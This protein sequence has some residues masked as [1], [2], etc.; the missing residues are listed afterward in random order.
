MLDVEYIQE[1]VR[2]AAFF[3]MEY[4]L[5]GSWA[6]AH[7]FKPVLN[8]SELAAW[9]EIMQIN[10]PEDY[11]T[12]LTKLGNGGAGPAYGI[13]PFH[14]PLYE[15]LKV[16]SIY[17]DENAKLFNKVAQE[18]FELSNTDEE[19][20]Y[21]QYKQNSPQ[22]QKLSFNEWEEQFFDKY[23]DELEQKLMNNG[24]LFIANQG[25]SIDIYMILN[26]TERGKC[27]CTNID[28]DYAY[29]CTNEQ[30]K[31]YN[32]LSE[33][34]P[35]RSVLWSEYKESLTDFKQYLMA[36]VTSVLDKIEDFSIELR[37]QFQ[38][39]REKVLEFEQAMQE[40]DFVG[41]ERLIEKLDPLSFSFKTR[42]YYIESLERLTAEFPNNILLQKFLSNVKYKPNTTRAYNSVVFEHKSLN[43]IDYPHPTFEEFKAT[44]VYQM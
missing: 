14:L 25:C 2:K 37:Q 32:L 11:K 23:Y 38:Y 7:I 5:F 41:I 16:S 31:Q 40:Q 20:L 8:E 10:L 26:G 3:D 36:Y 18:W 35:Y 28:Y 30:A 12:Y 39:E 43:N 27:H 24:Q 17:S 44:F 13:S 29:P 33:P 6:H 15:H 9:E 1:A 22:E 21:E 42:S 34:R 4:K 19:E